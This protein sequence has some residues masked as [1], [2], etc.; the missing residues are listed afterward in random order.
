VTRSIR[1]AICLSA[2]LSAG[3]ASGQAQTS[4]VDEA[5]DGPAVTAPTAFVYVSNITNPSGPT[6]IDD[7][8]AFTAAA[9]GK[10]TPVAGS[11]FKDNIFNLAVNGKYLFGGNG[12]GN[13]DSYLMETSGA[14]K[15]VETINP[16]TYNPGG[17]G[18][19]GDFR[20]DH[21]G[22]VLYNVSEDPD[23][24]GTHFQYFKISDTTGKLDYTSDTAELG[25]SIYEIDFLGNNKFAYS[26]ICTIYDHEEVGYT[27][28]LAR[29][30]NGDLTE[31]NLGNLGPVTPEVGNSYCP[32]TFSTDPS[33]HMAALLQD[34]DS[35]GD[36]YGL[37]V[38][39]TYT[40]GANGA[41]T[42][43]STHKNMPVLETATGAYEGFSM[44]MSPSGKYLAVGAI[45]GLEIFH[46][47]G[48]A[49]A[50]KYKILLT[51]NTIGEVYWDNNNH[52]YALVSNSPGT[53]K[54]YVYTV[55]S[56]SVTE[57]T[58]SP[59]SIPNPYS[60]IVQPK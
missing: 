31:V 23:C 44:R 60:V 40:A 37:P 54:L 30:S 34:E 7:V 3:A 11:P 45:N 1:L 17:C 22:G 20:I 27:V 13:I 2:A 59:Y 10:L 9:D 48:T 15:K 57:A 53:G 26:P 52:L 6:Y 33:D 49:Q 4:Q 36:L 32:I 43:S 47:S 18:N 21:T 56:T 46:F 38:I 24:F 8:Y 29:H 16:T 14:L 35:D 58:G 5:A 39:A 51:G 55:T 50:T 28:G 19:P 25:T 12:N 42:T 41:L